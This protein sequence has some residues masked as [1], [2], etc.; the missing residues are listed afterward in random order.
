[1][2]I[3]Q[4]K[5]ENVKK[6]SVVEITPKGNLVQITGRNGQGK[7]SILDSI[8]WALGGT[9]AIQSQPVKAGEEQAIIRLDL[10]DLIVT[11]KLGKGASLTVENAEGARY[12]SPQSMLDAMLG[13][14]TFD[15][16]AFTKMKPADQADEL[17]RITGLG[18]EIDDLD[19]ANK[20]DFSSRTD[21]NRKAKE[22]RAA[23]GTIAVPD[24][25]P[26]ERIDAATLV[27]QLQQAGETNAQIE[28]RKA[29]REAA[30]E[31][32]A[33]NRKRADEI[34]GGVEVEVATI[35]LRRDDVL[36]DLQAQ[37][38]ALTK[39]MVAVKAEAS[40]SITSLSAARS[41]EAAALRQEADSLQG[42]LDG[43]ATLPDPVDTAALR[44]QIA[45][46]DSI[47]KGIDA[48]ERRDAL[49]RD[50]EVAEGK[51]AELT[52]AMEGRTAKKLAAIAAANMPVPGLGLGDGVVLYNGIPLDQASGAEQLR[53]SVAIAMAANP[54]LRVL[55]IKEG[56]LLDDEG[57][58][59]L[60]EMA[61]AADYQVWLERVDSSGKVGVVIEDGHVVADNQA[62]DL[63][64]PAAE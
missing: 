49:I 16:L 26:A 25:L 2:K 56:S 44:E 19:A 39:R 63:F 13:E 7:T 24:N 58:A 18:S 17:R 6:L 43:A 52:T 23:A 31:K 38:D 46:A 11:R 28:Q 32:I 54:K 3:V 1:M 40:D 30:V 4:F 53:V 5:A 61:T 64:T 57:L 47:N 45:T 37:I 9:K 51:S 60:A 10:G 12:Q 41:S 62:V 48:R 29:N 59:M 35:E 33:A 55:R 14:M 22:A 8:L 50:A 20:T 42:K 15:P 27:D 36:S 34:E 21:W